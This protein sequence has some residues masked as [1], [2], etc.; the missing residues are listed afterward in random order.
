MVTCVSNLSNCGDILLG[1]SY[2]PKKFGAKGNSGDMVTKV[3]NR[4]NPQLT[5]NI[6]PYNFQRIRLYI[7]KYSIHERY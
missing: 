2:Q 4:D 3:E 1:F 5:V 6:N 7:Q